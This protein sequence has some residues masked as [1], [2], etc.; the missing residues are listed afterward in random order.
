MPSLDEVTLNSPIGKV[1]YK[2]KIGETC[3]YKVGDKEVKVR[4]IERKIK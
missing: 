2:K 3:F 1:I 4:I